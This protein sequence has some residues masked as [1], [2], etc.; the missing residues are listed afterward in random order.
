MNVEGKVG[1]E[2]D[3]HVYG[4]SNENTMTTDGEKGTSVKAV[5]R[6]MKAATSVPLTNDGHHRKKRVTSTKQ[7]GARSGRANRGF[8]KRGGRSDKNGTQR[9]SMG[10]GLID[11]EEIYLIVKSLGLYRDHWD[12][13]IV[14]T[15][16]HH[17]DSFTVKT[18]L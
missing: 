3:I 9:N 11:K 15:I 13:L 6:K 8:G 10:V 17:W 1:D 16:I 5:R 12:N 7:G 2:Y 14:G 4:K 18:V